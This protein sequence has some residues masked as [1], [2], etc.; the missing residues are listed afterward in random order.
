MS[1]EHTGQVLHA[2]LRLAATRPQ[3]LA[4]HAEA[5]RILAGAE[6]AR[7][8][9]AWQRRVVFAVLALVLL[10]VALTLAGVAC[11]LW[12]V[13]V[14]PPAMPHSALMAAPHWALMVAPLL[15]LLLAGACA[16]AVRGA[17]SGHGLDQLGQQWRAD[18]MMLR[19]VSDT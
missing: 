16:L 4:D 1:N 11:M 18:L 12:A 7:A 6:L 5:Y 17:S 14:P 2:L 15:P 8:A 3:L 9:Q 13:Q 19:E 10:A